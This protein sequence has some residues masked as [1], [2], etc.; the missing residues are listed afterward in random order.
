MEYSPEN[1]MPFGPVHPSLKEP[2][3]FKLILEGA[4]I[5][6]VR[7][8]IGYVHRGI[9]RAAQDRSWVKNI[10][11]FE[12]ICGICSFA[13]S[14]GYTQSV[15]ALTVFEV[16]RRAKYIRVIVAEL[17]RI[18][19]HMLWLGLVGHW[20][21]FDTLFMWIWKDREHVLDLTE[22]ITGNRVHKSYSTFGGVRKDLPDGFGE[23]LL[24]EMSFI[25]KR[26]HYYN[27]LVQSEETLIVRTKGVGKISQDTA[28][29]LSPVGPLLRSTGIARDVRVE[30]P[31]AAYDEIIP[32]V[33]TS[34]D[35]DIASLLTLR[36][37][38]V[39]ESC[40]LIRE[41]IEKLPSGPFKTSVPRSVPRGESSLHVEAPRGEL[42]YFVKS[43]GSSVPS[44][45]KI[46]TPTMAN[47]LTAT[48]MLKG[49]PLADV[50]IVLTGMDPCFGCMDRVSI[51]D[52][53]RSLEWACSGE[54]LRQYGI[55]Y[56]RR[57]H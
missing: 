17:E 15:E 52:L 34:S 13:H 26:A 18:H 51:V 49:H 36:L 19:S 37:G 6:E 55:D 9:E 1:M 3:Y 16:P 32:E 40:R 56:Y 35:G 7:P 24:A 20:A 12:R 46:R 4:K 47:L 25:E 21:G 8:R 29:R 53:D 48:E 39:L 54:Q 50:P 10:Y 42:F 33:Q 57:E 45:V 2:E 11:L 27:K 41:A 43:E 28:R 38:E 5:K 14:L 22:A 30:D 31:Y 23:K 44:R